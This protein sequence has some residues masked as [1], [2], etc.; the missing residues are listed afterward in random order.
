[1]LVA[2]ASI[3]RMA[4]AFTIV[5]SLKS[6]YNFLGTFKTKTRWKQSSTITT[7]GPLKPT[8]NILYYIGHPKPAPSTS[9]YCTQNRFCSIFLHFQK[10]NCNLKPKRRSWCIKSIKIAALRKFVLVQIC[11]FLS[12]CCSMSC[13][14]FWV[15]VNGKFS[16]Q[17]IK[18][19]SDA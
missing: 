12:K 11:F 9:V 1:V 6:I 13:S 14:P 10:S 17:K 7:S 18:S 15:V 19:A 5:T 16:E 3:S 8:S 4:T 2:Q